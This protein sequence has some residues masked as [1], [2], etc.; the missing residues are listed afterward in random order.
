MYDMSTGTFSCYLNEEQ[1]FLDNDVDEEERN[2]GVLGGAAG[3][4][5]EL[6]AGVFEGGIECG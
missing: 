5:G 3:G 4:E 6:A 1:A 2:S